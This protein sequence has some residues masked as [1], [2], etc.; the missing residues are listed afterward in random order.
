LTQFYGK[1]HDL[2]D[3]L[4]KRNLDRLQQNPVQASYFYEQNGLSVAVGFDGCQVRA[5]L[6][7]PNKFFEL[8]KKVNSVK[9]NQSARKASLEIS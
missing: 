4:E 6:M 3:G 5:A 1:F 7:P 2:F 9:Y 8:A